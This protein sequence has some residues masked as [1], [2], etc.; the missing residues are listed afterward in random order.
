MDGL[1]T[2]ACREEFRGWLEGRSLSSEGVWL[3]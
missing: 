2:F 3:S 1:L